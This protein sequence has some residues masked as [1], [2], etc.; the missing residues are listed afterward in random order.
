MS[1]SGLYNKANIFLGLIEY[2]LN[3]LLGALHLV[4]YISFH[5]RFDLERYLLNII[6]Q[7]S[8]QL[9]SIM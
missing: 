5:I 9:M 3:D 8:I 1:S 2:E 4:G 6:R 7:Y